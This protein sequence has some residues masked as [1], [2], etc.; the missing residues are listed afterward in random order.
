MQRASNNGLIA[1]IA[2]RDLCP[3]RQSPSTACAGQAGEQL[4]RRAVA[5]S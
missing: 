4:A 3:A 5:T 1:K 2:G